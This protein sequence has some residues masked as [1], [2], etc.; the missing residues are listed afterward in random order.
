MKKAQQIFLFKIS[1]FSDDAGWLSFFLPRLDTRKALYSPSEGSCSLISF[2]RQLAQIR[3]LGETVSI[4]Q[5]WN[6]VYTEVE[7]SKK[8]SMRYRNCLMRCFLNK[9]SL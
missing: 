1:P 3:C 9:V 8:Q 7:V 5:A 2:P 6:D 4:R